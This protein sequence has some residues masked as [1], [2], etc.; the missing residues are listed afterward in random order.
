M[1]HAPRMCR[2]DRRIGENASHHLVRYKK[3]W[4][5]EGGVISTRTWLRFTQINLHDGSGI[6][7]LFRRMRSRSSWHVGVFVARPVD[8]REVKLPR[9]S[10]NV[11][12]CLLD[13]Q[14]NGDAQDAQAAFGRYETL[15][16]KGWEEA[17]ERAGV[18]L[19][20]PW[21][22]VIYSDE[23]CSN[24]AEF[25]VL[26]QVKYIGT[27]PVIS[28]SLADT[29]CAELKVDGMLLHLNEMLRTTYTL[30]RP[31]LPSMLQS[32]VDRGFDFG[33]AYGYLRRFWF[34]DFTRLQETM[35]E[36]EAT[37]EARRHRA[38]DGAY[39]VDRHLPPR[40]VWDLY[41][42]RVLPWWV[43]WGKRD[44]R[45]ETV[46]AVSHSWVR[47]YDLHPVWTPING[48]KWPVPI[49]N[50]TTLDRV[51]VELLNVGREVIWLDVL[52][53]WQEGDQEDDEARL[54]EWKLDVPTIGNVYQTSTM[55]L[56][57]TYFNGLGLPFRVGDL[58]NGRHWLNRAWTLQEFRQDGII[59]GLVPGSFPPPLGRDGQII[60]SDPDVIRFYQRL[61][62]AARNSQHDRNIVFSLLA[63]MA[64][65]HAAHGVDKVGGITHILTLGKIPMYIRGYSSSSAAKNAWGLLIPVMDD[66]HRADLF[67]LYPARGNGKHAWCPSWDQ[68]N[69]DLPPAPSFCLIGGVFYRK[70]SGLF[71]C[72]CWLLG[73]CVLQGF[74][75]PDPDGHCRTGTLRL[76]RDGVEHSF[77]I[78]AHHQ[79]P[80]PDG[81]YALVG[82]RVLR[83]S[84]VV[85]WAVGMF[86]SDKRFEKLTVLR[87][88]RKDDIDKMMH[89]GL[90][91]WYNGRR[92]SWEGRYRDWIPLL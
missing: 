82:D 57:V 58:D 67:F 46:D 59:G 61:Q 56:V 62:G 36:W 70:K 28:S 2:A 45:L 37:D 71:E 9:G 32:Y 13:N 29:A 81:S 88:E 90:I 23:D 74:A 55:T 42:N 22:V 54:E 44:R 24:R 64:P 43:F 79:E 34:E 38:I 76:V 39:I 5:D 35:D 8:E 50:D 83:G 73:D 69:S 6:D 84:D 75:Q 66:K 68:V 4:A 72:Q 11:I 63:A 87:T 25:E 86:N 27:M 51:R 89:L 18:F 65:R 53:L 80:I 47:P 15:R 1:P 78:T 92:L 7:R 52:C 85:V 48:H 14:Y 26:R 16:R 41:S 60:D 21:Q 17:A 19:L 40:R 20:S 31:G 49:P 77:S 33:L 3:A 30:D 91:G 10:E 12:K